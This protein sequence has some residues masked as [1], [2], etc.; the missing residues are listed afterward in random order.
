[1]PGVLRI[2][3]GAAFPE[4]RAFAAEAKE[5]LENSIIGAAE[6]VSDEAERQQLVED[7]KTAFNMLSSLTEKETG[8]PVS[9]F[10]STSLSWV[11]VTLSQLVQKRDFADL[12]WHEIYVG[13]YLKRYMT[14]SKAQALSV[15]AHKRWIELDRVRLSLSRMVVR[16]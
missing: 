5:S 7:E 8:S 12:T 13:P 2:Y 11:A 14:E 16:D 1:M 3:E 6:N 10:I 15:E 9:Q 4:L